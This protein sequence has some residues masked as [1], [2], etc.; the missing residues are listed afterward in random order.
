VER[1][2]RSSLATFFAPGAANAVDGRVTLG[3]EA[4]H[5]ARVRR[6]ATGERVR[7]SDGAGSIV[8]GDV[9]SVSKHA[10]VVAVDM[11][12]LVKVIP[13]PGLHL[14]V[15]IADRDRTLWLAE[16]CAE[17][18]ITS[19]IPVMYARSRSVSPRADGVAFREKVKR[20]MIS[21]LEQSAGGWLPRVEEELSPSAAARLLPDAHRLVLD[22]EGE[23]I[24]RA[25]EA[26]VGTRS[27]V[28]VALGPEGG[29]ASEELT[30]LCDAG[31]RQAALAPTVLRFETAALAAVAVVRAVTTLD[32]R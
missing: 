17:L 14:L 12:S 10:L 21:A 31:W 2:D 18:A 25:I 22:A 27:D 28:A 8:L 6:L 15:P 32:A 30:L 7:L 16:K 4:A 11:P 1:S 19:W 24:L 13:P 26:H 3:E 5:H 9:V 20:R 29:F 23:P